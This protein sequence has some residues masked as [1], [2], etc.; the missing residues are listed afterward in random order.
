MLRRFVVFMYPTYKWRLHLVMQL[1]KL[2]IVTEHIH[3][4]SVNDGHIVTSTV[5]CICVY[6]AASIRPSHHTSL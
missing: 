2:R 1:D 3:R 4:V 6:G 5:K